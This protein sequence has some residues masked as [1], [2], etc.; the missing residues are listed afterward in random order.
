[1]QRLTVGKLTRGKLAEKLDIV[2][3]RQRR[4][5]GPNILGAAGPRKLALVISER[6]V[7]RPEPAARSRRVKIALLREITPEDERVPVAPM[8]AGRQQVA[9]PDHGRA[10]ARSVPGNSKL[11]FDIARIY[12]GSTAG[13]SRNHGR[14]SQMHE[15]MPRLPQHNGPIAGH[16][17]SAGDCDCSI[18]RAGR[19]GV[20]IAG[21]ARGRYL[22]GFRM[23]MPSNS[24]DRNGAWHSSHSTA[25]VEENGALQAGQRRSM[26]PPQ[27]QRSGI[28]SSQSTNQRRAEPQSR[29]NADQW[30]STL[31]RSSRSQ[32]AALPTLSP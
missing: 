21:L 32:S 8:W 1:M 31:R 9:R 29:Q 23:R 28:S 3:R 19:A 5:H 27:G 4:E 14:R 13:H 17:M 22:P 15:H 18:N 11:S 6:V 25:K 7:D 20:Q 26:T 10:R 2:G 24:G 30:P 16:G 12:A